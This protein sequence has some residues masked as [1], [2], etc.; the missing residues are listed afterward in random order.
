MTSLGDDASREDYLTGT[1]LA[2]LAYLERECSFKTGV[3][4]LSLRAIGEAVDHSASTVLRS[5]HALERFGHIKIER[6]PGGAYGYEV[7]D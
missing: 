1:E 7:Q 6:G 2:I 4:W 5:V 3:R